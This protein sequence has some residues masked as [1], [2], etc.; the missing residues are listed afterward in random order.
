MKLAMV[1]TTW[2]YTSYSPNEAYDN[3]SKKR[4]NYDNYEKYSSTSQVWKFWKLIIDSA[5]R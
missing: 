1:K 5:S 2:S 4:E 3:V